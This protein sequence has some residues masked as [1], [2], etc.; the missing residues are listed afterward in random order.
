MANRRPVLLTRRYQDYLTKIGSDLNR[1]KFDALR[2]FVAGELS[3]ST[4]DYAQT[5]F[6]SEEKDKCQKGR[7]RG[8]S[9]E[10]RVRQVAVNS[11]N[12]HP[13]GGHRQQRSNIARESGVARP[14]GYPH[15]RSLRKQPSKSPPLC[16]V[17]DD[18]K[19]RHFLADCDKFKH[20]TRQQQ[21]RKT[22]IDANRCLNCLSRGHLARNCNQIS[23]CRNVDL[24]AEISMRLRCMKRVQLTLQPWGLL[25]EGRKRPFRLITRTDDHP[26][27][28]TTRKVSGLDCS[29]SDSM[30]SCCVLTP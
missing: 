6:K 2:K 16:F 11:D 15:R 29:V 14:E 5:F 7:E 25:V 28:L 4:S 8:S 27:G 26:G 13:Y 17:C 1:P 20:L 12:G 24:T 21:Q 18:E 19:S 10:V 3:V 22:V 30:W 9:Q 23:K